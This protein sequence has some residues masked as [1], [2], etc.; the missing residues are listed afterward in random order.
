VVLNGP[1]G[2]HQRFFLA[3]PFGYLAL[4]LR[5]HFPSKRPESSAIALQLNLRALEAFLG[6]IK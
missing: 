1:L 4:Q 3:N 2:F 6:Q 5:F